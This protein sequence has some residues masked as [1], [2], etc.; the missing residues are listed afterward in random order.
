MYACNSPNELIMIIFYSFGTQETDFFFLK[1]NWAEKWAK[2][3]TVCESSAGRKKMWFYDE[4]V[5]VWG[6]FGH[7]ANSEAKI[8]PNIQCF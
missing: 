3:V 1:W 6:W 8:Y 2:N 7:I 5:S 4:R